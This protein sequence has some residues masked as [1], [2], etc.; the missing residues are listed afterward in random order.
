MSIDRANV[1]VVAF[2]DLG[3]S[4]TGLYDGLKRGRMFEVNVALL[5]PVV[6]PW[7][8]SGFQLAYPALI[9]KLFLS[10]EFLL[11]LPHP[12]PGH[13][14]PSSRG[15]CPS[16]LSVL[17]S[18]TVYFISARKDYILMMVTELSGVQLVWNHTRDFKIERA[19]SV[20]SIWNYKYDFRPK[21]H[22]TRFSYHFIKSILKLHNFM[23]SNFRFWCNV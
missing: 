12:C 3:Q 21:L 17:L 1:F 6:A 18:D 22:S 2:H 15:Y 23:A 9:C 19:R 16:V 11:Q 14:L 4:W 7:F 8:D 10:L 13:M 20:S 5:H